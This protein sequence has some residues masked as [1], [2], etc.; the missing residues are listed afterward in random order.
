[1]ARSELATPRFFDEALGRALLLATLAVV[2][3]T[4]LASGHHFCA[5]AQTTDAP[6]KAPPPTRT[7]NATDVYHGVEVVDSYRWLEDQN[8]TETR[9]WIEAQN[10]YTDS[11]LAATPGRE[12]LKQRLTALLKVDSI[13]L[14]RER[15]GR[16]FFTKRLANQDQPV[17][18]MRKGL[19]GTD[20]VLIDPHPLSPDYTI[21]VQLRSISRDG[22]AVVYGLRQGGE[23]E[24]KLRLFDVDARKDLPDRLPKARYFSTSLAPDKSAIYYCRMTPAGARVFWHKVGDD[25]AQDVEVFGKGYGPEKI[26]VS[27]LSE[28][29]RYL[30]VHV[31][32]GSAADRTEVHVQNLAQHGP[33]VAIVND[34]PARFFGTIAGDRLFLHTNWK[35]PKGRILGVDL[36]AP[37]RDH[38]REVVP[39]SGAVI[40]SVEA[41]GGR[42]GVVFTEN[43]SSRVK[44]LEPR[45]KLV[46]EISLPTIGSVTGLTGRWSS[47]EAFYQF[48]SFHIPQRIYRYDVVKGTQEM[49]A[50]VQAPIES[51]KYEV[52]QVWYTSKD[53]TKV[54]MFLV[55]ARGI[56]LDGSNPTLLTGYGGFN[57]SET[58]SYTTRAAAW[59]SS[60]GIYALPNLRGGGEFGEEWHRAGMLGN[61][62]NVFDD[63][64][65]AAE[66]LVRNNYTRPAHLA[67]RG[68][69]NGGLLVGAAL[70]QRPDL[71]GAVV[72]GYPLL[73]MLRYHKF[74][75]ARWWVPEYGSSDDP[76]Q[77]KYIYAYSPYQQ[78]KPGGKYPAVLLIS[79][80]S[81]TRV[82]PLHARKMTARLQAATA[83]SQPVLLHYDTKA[84]HSG[85]TPISK[86]VD[87]LT[88]E[89]SFLFWRLGLLPAPAS[90]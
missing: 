72:C 40:E 43:A 2:G 24:T 38:W 31:L 60:G 10:A 6:P 17:L 13:N 71:F 39:E 63:F 77:F 87:D 86:Q 62:Q 29:G 8:T 82:D 59:I 35:A 47:H 83:S 19:H 26:I 7:D 76:E 5:V 79:G 25:V 42:L 52:K 56:K 15:N 20:E 81:D 16:Y 58:P 48:E 28:D 65:A 4:A 46:R 45:G 49:W 21:T 1:M 33:M 88:D 67:I 30:L 34:L 74:L 50:Q 80:D 64:I 14:P 85:G 75:V 69:S 27:E 36:K 22:T 41:L 53:G 66:W 90:H 3:V 44:L 68:S 37:S 73:D 70:T 54:P 12:Q 51:D 32:Y 57:V 23:D 78:V 84:G 89:L 18:Y 9:A 11:L 55:Y 61:K